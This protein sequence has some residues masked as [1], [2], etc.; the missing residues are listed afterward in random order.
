MEI[1]ENE[2]SLLSFCRKKINF[3]LSIAFL[4]G[5]IKDG[6]LGAI[7]EEEEVEL[8]WAA[9][10]LDNLRM[11]KKVILEGEELEFV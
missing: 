11:K 4:R 5:L 10:D 3:M 7:Q 1:T 2:L 9:G 8:S 6:I